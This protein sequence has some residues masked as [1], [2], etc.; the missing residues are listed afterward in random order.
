[1]KRQQIDQIH[2]MDVSDITKRVS[3]LK[4]TV[5]V[6]KIGRYTKQAK[7]TRER[8]NIRREIAVLLT[9][10]AMKAAESK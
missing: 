9:V 4:K 8:K 3:E 10:K 2:S 1:M 5:A 6:G 7:N